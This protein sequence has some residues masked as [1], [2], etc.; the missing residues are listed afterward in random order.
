[1]YTNFDLQQT[2]QNQ[3]SLPIVINHFS[4]NSI[5]TAPL[6]FYESINVKTQN[7]IEKSDEKLDPAAARDKGLSNQWQQWVI[8]ILQSSQMN[9]AGHA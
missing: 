3:H 6:L 5:T 7:L 9:R 1:V 8:K 4:K 2:N